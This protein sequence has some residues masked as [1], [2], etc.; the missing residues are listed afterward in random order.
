MAEKGK[1]LIYD[2]TNSKSQE[3]SNPL[4]FS[5]KRAFENDDDFDTQWKAF[6]GLASANPTNLENFLTARKLFL[7]P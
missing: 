7:G 1:K 3:K 4:A 2:I 6:G 5:K